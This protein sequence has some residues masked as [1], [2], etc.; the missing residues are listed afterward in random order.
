[1]DDVADI[2]ITISGCGVASDECQAGGDLTGERKSFQVSALT[3]MKESA[4]TGMKERLGRSPAE[5]D[6]WMWTK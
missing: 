5:G 4:L 2:A 6:S 3:G 1:M